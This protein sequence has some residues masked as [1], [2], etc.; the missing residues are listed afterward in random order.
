MEE[1][2]S[3][4]KKETTASYGKTYKTTYYNLDCGL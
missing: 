1:K 4:S 3:F 2:I